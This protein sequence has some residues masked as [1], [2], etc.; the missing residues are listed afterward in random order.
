[1]GAS[2][3]KARA[4]Q[5]AIS[6]RTWNSI[7]DMLDWWKRAH[8]L[9]SGG[10]R[11]NG[12]RETDLIRLR[13]DTGAALDKYSV[14][15]VDEYLLTDGDGAVQ[16]DRMRMFFGGSKAA[17]GAALVAAIQWT[18]A[19]DEIV[20]A[21]VSGVGLALVTVGATWH[22]RAYP[23]RNATVLTSGV[24]GPFEILGELT[25]TGAQTCL[26]RMGQADNRSI[27]AR[28]GGSA[29]TAASWHDYN[30]WK[31]GS[32][33]VQIWEPTD[34]TG[35]YERGT[36]MVGETETD[37]TATAYNM[38]AGTVAANSMVLLSPNDEWLPVVTLE[39]CEMPAE[40]EET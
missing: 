2:P 13:N 14:L 3:E 20:E 39:P 18:A 21:Q 31:F 6:A 17:N 29:V 15:Q 10:G 36:Y 12:P 23:T 38:A 37:K 33:T 28:V 22:R 32:G 1:M 40:P 27:M 25:A 26:V 16:F 9:G 34:T 7:V 4:G 30:I 19:I 11:L 24:F 8:A 5:K 35:R